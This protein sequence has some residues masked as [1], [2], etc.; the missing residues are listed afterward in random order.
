[1][2]Y[3]LAPATTALPSL[4]AVLNMVSHVPNV[5]P[6]SLVLKEQS[7]S[8]SQITVCSYLVLPED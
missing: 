6:W 1:M 3:L 4:V 7:I 2:A 5:G 8:Y